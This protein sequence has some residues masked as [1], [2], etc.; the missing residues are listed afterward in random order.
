MVDRRFLEFSCIGTMENQ[1]L[2][3]VRGARHNGTQVLLPIELS[4]ALNRRILAEKRPVLAG[5]DNVRGVLADHG[6]ANAR[7]WTR[8]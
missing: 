2:Q 4:R 7:V 6:D 8:R 1:S 3:H 5:A